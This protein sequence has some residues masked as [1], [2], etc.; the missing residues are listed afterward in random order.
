VKSRECTKRT[1]N[2]NSKQAERCSSQRISAMMKTLDSE[3]I[4]EDI[5]KQAE[6]KNGENVE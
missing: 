2:A 1:T 5:T 4:T 6:S 3:Q